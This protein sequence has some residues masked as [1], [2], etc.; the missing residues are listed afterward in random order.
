MLHNNRELH[1]ELDELTL[2]IKL[3]YEFIPTDEA[4]RRSK[5]LELL[6]K[7]EQ[8]EKSL[9]K[10]HDRIVDKADLCEQ[11]IKER[12]FLRQQ[13][14]NDVQQLKKLV[15]HDIQEEK[16]EYHKA[17]R[18]YQTLMFF[19]RRF[20][21]TRDMLVKYGEDAR[22]ADQARVKEMWKR[23]A[24]ERNGLADAAALNLREFKTFYNLN[25]T[26]HVLHIKNTRENVQKYAVLDDYEN[27]ME[28]CVK[29]SIAHLSVMLSLVWFPVQSLLSY[30]S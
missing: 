22:A 20:L 13:Y 19:Y 10:Q 18:C 14:C 30:W 24:E 25:V 29:L 16:L 4:K 9:K 3:A 12:E 11:F 6:Q 1:T 7:K 15:L 2:A 26:Y 17:F 21:S 23:A 27:V 8:F 5:E 28:V